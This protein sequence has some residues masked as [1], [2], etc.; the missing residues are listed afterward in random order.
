MSAAEYAVLTQTVEG[1]LA[2]VPA[3][4]PRAAWDVLE[5]LGMTRVGIPED[6]GGSGGSWQ[7]AAIILRAMAA[8]SADAPLVE[9]SWGAGWLLAAAGLDVPAEPLSVVPLDALASRR[10]DGAYVV[11]GRV[12][13]IGAAALA[14][15]LVVMLPQDGPGSMIA[16]IDAGR[17]QVVPGETIAGTSRDAVEFHD[18]VLSPAELTPAPV[19]YRDVAL[20]MSVAMLAQAVG[21]A[22]RAERLSIEYVTTRVQFGRALSKFQAVQHRVAR[23]AA[24]ARFLHTASTTA[25]DVLSRDEDDSSAFLVVVSLVAAHEAIGEVAAQAHQLHGAIGF[26]QE[27]ALH[28]STTRL[29]TWRQELSDGRRWI[30]ELADALPGRAPADAWAQISLD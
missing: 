21:A 9:T 14:R 7:E 26:T 17:V 15:G 20:R 11:T 18:L 12:D 10:S 6:R 2:D 13:G 22:D 29:W 1:A 5:S 19:S 27:H 30:T 28:R 16:L 25:V 4:D 3:T 24:A 8:V 23:L